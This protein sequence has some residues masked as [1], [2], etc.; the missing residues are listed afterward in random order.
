M[1]RSATGTTVS[2]TGGMN[3]E[4]LG[5]TLVTQLYERD[6]VFS[7]QVHPRS[8]RGRVAPRLQDNGAVQ[9]PALGLRSAAACHAQRPAHITIVVQLDHQG[10]GRL[11]SCAA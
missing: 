3:G 4:L 1:Y 2:L 6:A 5:E 7:E 11:R 10:G 8:I 9:T